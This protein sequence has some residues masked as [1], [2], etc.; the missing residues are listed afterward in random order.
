MFLFLLF[1]ESLRQCLDEGKKC[2]RVFNECN[3]IVTIIVYQRIR[4]LLSNVGQQALGRNVHVILSGLSNTY[5]SYVTTPEEYQVQRYEGASTPYGPYTLTIHL[6][7]LQ[8]LAEALFNNQQVDAGPEPPNMDTQ[9]IS[10]QPGVIFDGTPAGR[11]FGAVIV[12]PLVSYLSG[13]QLYVRFQAG[14]PRNHLLHERSYFNIERQLADGNFQTVATD[15][16]WET[17]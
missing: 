13:Q 14:N 4:N 10:L 11:S 1:L 12:Q 6:V 17:K 5:A 7:Q 9:L 15:S 8:R 3:L 16:D 2:K